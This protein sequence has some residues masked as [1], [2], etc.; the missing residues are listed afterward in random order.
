[1]HMNIYV[2]YHRDD[3]APNA[4]DILKEW[5]K[6]S[7][8]A[9]ETIVENRF[10]VGYTDGYKAWLKQDLQGLGFSVRNIY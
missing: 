5:K 4:G 9:K 1:M 2:F 7:R 8:L 10:N 6:P 3:R